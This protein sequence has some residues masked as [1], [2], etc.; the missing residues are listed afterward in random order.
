MFSTTAKR[1]VAAT[2]VG[3]IV[4]LSPVVV[5]P[6]A[7]AAPVGVPPTA[8]QRC[9]HHHD[10]ADAEP[11]HRGPRR[12]VHGDRQGHRE[13]AGA[14]VPTGTVVFKYKGT[15]KTATLSGGTASVT[16]TSQRTGRRGGDLLRA[17]APGASPP[18]AP[19]PPA[20]SSWVKRPRAA[21]G[22]GNGGV[23]GTSAGIGGLAAT[24]LDNQTE[25]FG[26][27]GAGMVTVGGLALLVHRRRVQ[28]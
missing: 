4:A 14:P 2:F 10:D 25:L 11:E 1:I 27:L 20:R 22:N 24:G 9:R 18:S 13:P 17:C 15:T 19:A 5:A 8:V 3:G 12:D 23:A 26:V 7:N 21:A 28:A 6:A 16:F